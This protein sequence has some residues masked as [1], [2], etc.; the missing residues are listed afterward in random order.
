MK[1]ADYIGFDIMVIASCT[2]A[3]NWLSRIYP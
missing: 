2:M 1:P 3:V